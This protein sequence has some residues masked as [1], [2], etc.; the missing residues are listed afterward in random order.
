VPRPD[1]PLLERDATAKQTRITPRTSKLSRAA[2]AARV[3][4]GYA[5]SSRTR[6]SRSRFSFRTRTSRRRSASRP[7]SGRDAAGA[8]HGMCS[9]RRARASPAWM[10][11][12]IHARRSSTP[13]GGVPHSAGN[14]WSAAAAARR[15]VTQPPRGLLPAAATAERLALPCAGPRGRLRHRELLDGHGYFAL[16]NA[17]PILPPDFPITVGVGFNVPLGACLGIWPPPIDLAAGRPGGRSNARP[18]HRSADCRTPT[19]HLFGR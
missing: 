12:I 16:G 5:S 4:Q 3:R 9:P 11:R 19:R 6:S 2:A 10:L 18:P 14:G 1:P 15:C 17:V 13:A 8:S 7:D